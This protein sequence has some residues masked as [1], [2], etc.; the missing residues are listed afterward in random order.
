MNELGM[1]Y[2]ALYRPV[3][4]GG[5]GG[6]TAA[7]HICKSVSPISA[8]EVDRIF[9]LHYYCPPPFGFSDL[10]MALLYT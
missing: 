3:G 5:V 8:R 4:T 10:P 6:A 9:P 2:V 1:N 7:L